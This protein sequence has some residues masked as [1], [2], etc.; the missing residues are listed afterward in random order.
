MDLGSLAPD[1][2]AIS[3][4]CIKSNMVQPTPS[5][6]LEVGGVR[7]WDLWDLSLLSCPCTNLCESKRVQFSWFLGSTQISHPSKADPTHLLYSSADG[8]QTFLLL[9]ICLPVCRQIVLQIVLLGGLSNSRNAAFVRVFSVVFCLKASLSCCSFFSG[10]QL[11]ISRV[12]RCCGE[13]RAFPSLRAAAEALE[14]QVQGWL[15]TTPCAALSQPL[16]T[17]S[18]LQ[19]LLSSEAWMWQVVGAFWLCC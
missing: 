17:S 11:I 1:F 18:S 15:S 4:K 7:T 12:R 6:G 3:V 8:W 14:L 16:R 10:F 2:G 9:I 13:S 19:G 5:V